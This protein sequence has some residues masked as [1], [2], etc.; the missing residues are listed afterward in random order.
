MARWLETLASFDFD[1]T[2][3]PGTQHSNG[4]A[5]SRRP[6]PDDCNTCGRSEDKDTMKKIRRKTKFIFKQDNENQEEGKKSGYC[7]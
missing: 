1:I 4:E 3:R 7:K 6:C 2:Y 5:L